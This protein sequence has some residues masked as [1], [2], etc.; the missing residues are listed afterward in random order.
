MPGVD[1]MIWEKNGKNGKI[2]D[3]FQALCT[4][5]VVWKSL[6]MYI[7]F[8]HSTNFVSK[9]LKCWKKNWII[10]L[11]TLGSAG[12]LQI[13]KLSRK[14]DSNKIFFGQN[15]WRPGEEEFKLWQ[16]SLE[17]RHFFDQIFFLPRKPRLE[18]TS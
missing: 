8:I 10:L 15:C 9:K 5:N 17:Y 16:V 12:R 11:L 2:I 18:E 6:H 4:Y 3:N 7:G 14:T 13:W 1:V